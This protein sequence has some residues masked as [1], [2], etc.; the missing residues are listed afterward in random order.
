MSAARIAAT[1]ALFLV[2]CAV[3]WIGISHLVGSSPA[4]ATKLA[5]LAQQNKQSLLDGIAE[6]QPLYFKLEKYKTNRLGPSDYPDRVIDET[7]LS[8]GANGSIEAAVATMRSLDGELLGYTRLENGGLVFTDVATGMTFN[9]N[10][11]HWGSLESSV[12]EVWN[13]PQALQDSGVE[14]KGRGRLNERESLIYEWT[15]TSQGGPDSGAQRS[16]LKRIELVEDA[17]LLFKE[18]SYEVDDQG[19]K[20]LIEETTVVEYGL[21]PEGSTVP[22]VA[23][24]SP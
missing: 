4:T 3:A 23:D 15:Y 20:T 13:R 18:S 22:T 19:V 7:W 2:L 6:G 14:F 17:P 24:G 8:A 1:G 11:D 12:N 16:M 5:T 10:V 9:I 21:L